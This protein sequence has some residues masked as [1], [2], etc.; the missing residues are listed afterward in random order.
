MQGK[1]WQ[2]IPQTPGGQHRW[3][4]GGEEWSVSSGSHDALPGARER[5]KG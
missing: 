5:D 1:P 3:G 2:G 4:C